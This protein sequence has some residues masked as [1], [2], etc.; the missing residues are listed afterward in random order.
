MSG[1]NNSYP[2][3]CVGSCSYDSN[4]GKCTGCGRTMAEIKEAYRRSMKN[5][6]M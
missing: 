3:G 1:T 4:I 2:S 6:R 5:V